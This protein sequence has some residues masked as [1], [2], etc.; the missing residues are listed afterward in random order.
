MT[1]VAALAATRAAAWDAALE[2]TLSGTTALPGMVHSRYRRVVN[3]LLP[4]DRLVALA[5][6][7]LDDAPWTVRIPRWEELS[8][9]IG[10][11]VL[12]TARTLHLG[13]GVD[14]RLD[15]E[16]AWSPRPAD[17]SSLTVEELDRASRTLRAAVPEP[18]TPFGRAGADLLTR[19]VDTLRTALV[20]QVGAQE[21]SDAV[22]RLVGL[23]EGLTPSG[24]DVLVGLVLVAAQP[25]THL[26]SQLP[27]LRDA[28][29][30]HA[31]RTTLLSATTLRAAA[32]GRARQSL[33]DLVGGLVDGTSP[34][35]IDRVLAIG[36]S[37]GGD[38]LRGI[39]LA[40]AAE[41]DLRVA[42]GQ[43]VRPGDRKSVV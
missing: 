2:E 35:A 34:A 41:H 10:A 12:L 43:P 30:Q 13:P 1:P 31:E 4:G 20:A 8:P 9:R 21:T 14:V 36:H 16:R 42:R 3:L 38:L 33:H 19:G 6:S 23:G 22:G 27:S 17:L 32:R 18:T 15:P 5:S 39:A 28:V 11:K 25:G 40:L 24:D 7:E 37:S 26:G 29:E